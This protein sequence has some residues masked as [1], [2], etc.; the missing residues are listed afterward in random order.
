MVR[1]Q[2]Q[3]VEDLSSR[4]MYLCGHLAHIKTQVSV[5]SVAHNNSLYRATLCYRGICSRRVSVC[6]S[7]RHT[8]ALYQNG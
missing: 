6:L 7:V 2:I 3:A 1:S 4:Y 8:L 5:V